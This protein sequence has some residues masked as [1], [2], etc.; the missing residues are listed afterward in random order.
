MGK[1]SP[2][3]E[4]LAHWEDDSIC[5]D[6]ESISALVG[7]LPP[8]AY[9]HDEWWGNSLRKSTHTWAYAWLIAGWRKS[10]VDTTNRT[11]VFERLSPRND[12]SFWWVNHKQTWKAEYK[13]GYI[14]SPTANKNGAANQ[15][16]LNLRLVRAGDI[17]FSYAGG[18][19][20]GIGIATAPYMDCD[21]PDE[22]WQAE[23]GWLKAGWSVPI[24][25]LTL[26]ESW[27]PKANLGEIRQLLPDKHSPLQPETGDGNQGC[28]LARVSSQFA[29]KVLE[30]LRA[31]NMAVVDEVLAEATT[32]RLA[33]AVSLSH[34]PMP[35]AGRLPAEQLRNITSE[36]IWQAVQDLLQGAT[37]EG[38]GESTDYDLLADG[39]RLAPKQVLGL[40]GTAALGFQL[41]PS[42]FTAGKGSLCFELLQDAGFQIV[43]KGEELP[44]LELPIEPEERSW[45]EG[46]VKLVYHLHK[47]RSTGLAQAKKEDFRKKH[48][49]RLFCEECLLDPVQIWGPAGEACIEVH[50]D[51]VHVADM[52][53]GHLSSLE[54]LK[55]L[56]ANCHRVLHRKLRDQLAKIHSA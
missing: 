30:L 47:E 4:Y 8:S 35:A 32:I 18:V 25:W 2:F 56:C 17:V 54:E 14:W 11:V 39:V 51:E 26:A 21:I 37:V 38:F 40:A 43:P 3:A 12:P 33:T 19:V 44:D 10:K 55:C 29:A 41:K 28:Y 7:G 13:Q 53:P 9:D 42:H 6:F 50:H 46:H 16:Y 20:R 15:T 52:K 34:A 27:S 45:V 23:E 48:N 36:F 31:E 5:L 22:H 24:R 1:Y 49:G